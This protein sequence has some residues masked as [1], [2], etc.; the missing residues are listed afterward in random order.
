MK[1]IG[2]MTFHASHNYGSV[3]QAYALQKKLNAEGYDAKIINYRTDTQRSCYPLR[4]KYRGL[5]GAVRN[6]W[7][8]IIIGKLKRR[9]FGFEDFIN[10]VL[11]TTHEIGGDRELSEISDDFDTLICGSD[12]IWNPACQDFKTAYYLD[13]AEGKRRVA[14]AP[15]LGK[16]EFDSEDRELIARLLDNIDSISVREEKGAELLSELTDKPVATVCD[17]VAL[18]DKQYWDEVAVKPKIKK[19]Y[20]L[21]YFLNNNHGNRGYLDLIAKTLGLK[22]V[23]LNEI[24]RD[25]ARFDYKKAYGAYPLEFI[26]LIK[27]AAFVYTNSF[28]ATAFSTIFNVPFAS[29]IADRDNVSNNNDSRKIDF[30]KRV[31]LENNCKKALTTEEITELSKMSFDGANER[32]DAWRKESWKYLYGAIENE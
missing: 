5:K 32:L 25:F 6:V 16:A 27:N 4:H 19:P 13:F 11:P 9:Y 15:S 21:C 7:Q 29:M 17:P 3:L 26:G 12:Q 22:V 1:K 23:V 2:I 18:L 31:G 24:I 20:V 8:E 10:N 14:Y 30:L 28:H